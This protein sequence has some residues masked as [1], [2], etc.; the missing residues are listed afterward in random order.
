MVIAIIAIFALKA[1]LNNLLILLIGLSFLITSFSSYAY[2]YQ[3]NG[4]NRA[5][6]ST[7]IAIFESSILH[8]VNEDNDLLFSK[9]L[10]KQ[11]LEKYYDF[12]LKKFTD[13]YKFETYFYNPEDSSM[14][15][16]EECYAVEVSFEA[17]LIF[18]FRYHR[19]L[20]F[21]IFDNSYGS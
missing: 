18:N 17:S 2:S 3:V 19:V 8:N 1:R 20:T 10:I 12:S 16:D 13:K 6:I 21:E 15:I 9:T 4:I 7:P 5:I 14:C 11:K